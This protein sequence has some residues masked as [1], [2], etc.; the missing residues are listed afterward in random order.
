MFYKVVKEDLSSLVMDYANNGLVVQYKQ[1]EFVYA[2]PELVKIGFGLFV[3]D[4]LEQARKYRLL[5][6]IIFECEVENILPKRETMGYF[7]RITK[8]EILDNRD[9]LSAVCKLAM[10]LNSIMVVGVKLIREVTP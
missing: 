8:D 7:T 1:G 9:N 6:D 3:F 5:D 2:D 10:P 4:C